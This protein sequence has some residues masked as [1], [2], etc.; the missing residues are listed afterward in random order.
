MRNEIVK[1]AAKLFIIAAI[2][3]LALGM[4]N[5]LTKGPIEVQAL[6]E[7][8]AARVSV[9]PGSEAFIEVAKDENGLAEAYRGENAAG[10]PV[11]YTGK[12]K[13]QGFGGEIEITVGVNLEG[14]IT[15]VSVGGPNFSETVGLGAKTKEPAFYGQFAGKASPV[16]LKKDGGEIDAVTSATISST[17]VT[18]GVN[19]AAEALKALVAAGR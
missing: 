18:N 14:T 1:V 19:S 9:L 5:A 10:E 12:I 3:G 7:A 13:V 15:G 16:A 8:N 11:G 17:A 2:A 4:T 6:A